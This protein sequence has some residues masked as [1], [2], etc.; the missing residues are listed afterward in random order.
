VAQS[1]EGKGDLPKAIEQYETLR[2]DW[3][4]PGYIAGK[5]D[6]MKARSPEPGRRREGGDR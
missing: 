3:D 1:L 6:R 2:N 4:N 5:I